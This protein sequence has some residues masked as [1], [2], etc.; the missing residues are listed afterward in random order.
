MLSTMNKTL[1]RSILITLLG[2]P[3][4][5]TAQPLCL[6]FEGFPEG[7]AFGPLL[8][9]S[10][11]DTLFDNQ[12][13]VAIARPFQ[14][15]NGQTGFLNASIEGPGLGWLDSRFLFMGNNALE[16]RYPEAVQEVCFD[17]F[18][19]GGE[20]NLSVNGGEP[21]LLTSFSGMPE[22]AFPGVA[23]ELT[24]Q[25]GNS[26][27][28]QGQ[29][30]LRGNITALLVGGQELGIDNVCASQEASQDS[31]CIGF[32]ALASGA[33]GSSSG[34]Q[35]GTTFYT[36]AGVPM[37]LLPFQSLF[38]ATAYGDVIAGAATGSFTAAAGQAAR[39]Q[40]ANLVLDLT[41]YPE[42]AVEVVADYYYE[43]GAVNFAAN[44]APFLIQGSL[45]AGFFALAPGATLEVVPDSPNAAQGTLRFSGGLQTLLMGGADGLW[46]DNICINPE[47]PACA[48][49]GLAVSFLPCEQ[50]AG[51]F[52]E[53]DVSYESPV[54]DTLAISVG[55]VV[56]YQAYADLPATVGPIP[57]APA[58]LYE[59]FAFDE[60]DPSCFVADTLAAAPCA[61]C[62]MSGMT[63]A[64][65]G[66]NEWGQ[67]LATLDFDFTASASSPYFFSLYFDGELFGYFN[68]N[69][70]PLTFPVPCTSGPV[71]V[72]SVCRGSNSLCC[73]EL[74]IIFAPSC[75]AAC[76]LEWAG[77][78]PVG[79]PECTPGAEGFY[80]ISL[81]FLGV[82]SGDTLLAVSTLTGG[83]AVGI[84][85]DGAATFTLPLIPGNTDEI[86][87]MVYGSPGC[88]TQQIGFDIACELCEVSGF[89]MEPLPCSPGDTAF[90][91]NIDFE[92]SGIHSDTFR[93]HVSNTYQ[94]MVSQ[95]DLPA[96]VGPIPFSFTGINYATISDL[97][98]G[99]GATVAFIPPDCE[100][101]CPLGAPTVV[102]TG[103]GCNEDGTYNV[104]ILVPGVLPGEPLSVASPA[105]GFAQVV[106]Y[107]AG[108]SAILQLSGWP[109]PEGGLDSLVICLDGQPGCCTTVE[110]DVYCE[111][112]CSVDAVLDIVC[113]NQPGTFLVYVA[114]AS[115]GPVFTLATSLGEAS[116]FQAAQLPAFV[117]PFSYPG[118][119]ANISV[120]VSNGSCA[121]F[122][123]EGYSL[124]C[125][126]ACGLGFT[127]LANGAE[128]DDEGFYH[129]TLQL[130]GVSPGDSILIIGQFSNYQA[131][132]EVGPN[133]GVEVNLPDPGTG[134]DAVTICNLE[135]SD[136]CIEA[137]FDIECPPPAEC[138]FQ[139]VEASPSACE[140]GQFWIELSVGV[141]EPG[142]L[143]YLAFV[144]GQVFGPFPY[145]G[146][147]VNL[148]P[149]TAGGA[150][151]YDILVLDFELPTCFGYTEI[152]PIDCE[153]EPCA[154]S[155]LTAVAGP[156]EQDGTYSLFVDFELASPGNEFVEYFINGAFAGFSPASEFPGAIE[157]LMPQG[158]GLFTFEIC[159][160]DQA[161]CCASATFEAPD[162]DNTLCNISD[163]LVG[164][165]ECDEEGFY[166]EAS[167][168]ST[169]VEPGEEY[170]A[171][172][173]GVAYGVFTY[174]GAFPILGPFDPF[175]DQL[176]ELTIADLGHPNCTASTEFVAFDCTGLGEEGC[177]MFEPYTGFATELAGAGVLGAMEGLQVGYEIAENAVQ[178][179]VSVREVGN[180]PGFLTGTGAALYFR[181]AQFSVELGSLPA[182]TSAR[183]LSMDYWLGAG[184]D[185][186][187]VTA[188]DW[189][190]RI[191]VPFVSN[192]YTLE[193]GIVLDFMVL[194]SNF[195]RLSVTGPLEYFAV[196]T[197]PWQAMAIDHLCVGA[198]LEED[199]CLTFEPFA[200]FQSPSS[201]GGD[202]WAVVGTASGVELAYLLGDF[203]NCAFWVQP[204]AGVSYFDAAA[205]EML[206]MEQA[207]ARFVFQQPAA[208]VSFDYSIQE[209][210]LSYLRI[211]EFIHVGLDTLGFNIPI[212][213]PD[214][215]VLEKRWPADSPNGGNS[216]QVIITGA[217]SEFYLDGSG[218]VDN[219][220]WEPVEE[221]VWPGDANADNLAHHVDLL[222]IGLAYG[223]QGPERTALGNSWEPASS[224]NWGP[225]FADGTNFKHADC[226]GDG[227]IDEQDI[228]AIELNY[229]LSHGPQNDLPEL[230]GTA[231]DPPAYV[232][233]PDNQPDGA[234]FQAPIIVGEA[235]QPVSNAY[236]IAFTVTFDPEVIDPSSIEIVYPVS[237]FGEPGINTVNIHKIY[238]EEGRIEMALSRIDHNNVSGHGQVA[239]IIG[240]IDDI[241]GIQES[242]IALEHILCLDKD[243]DLLPIQGLET[244]FTV[245]RD[246]GNEPPEGEGL[247][248]VFPN[249]TT[250]RVAVVSPQGLPLTGLKLYSIQG[251][252][253]SLPASTAPGVIDLGHLPAG[254]YL[255]GVSTG[256]AT[257]YRRIIRQAP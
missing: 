159:V 107:G 206:G 209:S 122:V 43:G 54:S 156:C 117:G 176:Y 95:S 44:G 69:E 137:S 84:V 47:P 235:A 221:E 2:A 102:G 183:T 56:F 197:Y 118:P 48:L 116:Q 86:Y 203:C 174:G 240:V 239:Y 180:I 169:G 196:Q 103:A 66:L 249:P 22:G 154:I 226:N 29:L 16:L 57:V 224:M 39:F 99:C 12:G 127:G 163:L 26:A 198:F 55:D 30:C 32:N 205:G 126:E 186:L 68:N 92:A 42:P 247:F 251:R 161:E 25:T 73:T 67:Q 238:P 38:W 63:L 36:E 220:C 230:P 10:P 5:I 87:V 228:A 211:D 61:S 81:S 131:L 110:V 256:E 158:G 115:P 157:G 31:G 184:T 134:F 199:G 3:F 97:N 21:L 65:A 139:F 17:F 254:V 190:E 50:N 49:S 214:G 175:T 58:N 6:D 119:N 34:V 37:L 218:F 89:A 45:Q 177:F 98:G 136:C 150:A 129:A 236:G 72:L 231:L 124:N 53:V 210:D 125:I 9:Q 146:Q 143:G 90:Y 187:W 1:L 40:E 41:G 93:F 244:H 128:C 192:T 28:P 200:G 204:S 232:D 207:L 123:S 241:A 74:P 78:G 153:T 51:F 15:L 164:F 257:I 171:V 82:E 83:A 35:P 243:E 13:L 149:F 165:V 213:L 208:Q 62:T 52:V 59:V 252:E 148:G 145:N 223:A 108:G 111:P 160:N 170:Q 250:G 105:T 168:N 217:L 166:V 104:P 185:S 242:G 144:D 46:L 20:I 33:Y 189:S 167:F 79:L 216:A 80:D 23:V 142:S 233:F 121:P 4:A 194:A 91:A 246:T 219:L 135:L 85:D 152:G 229:G 112:N 11:G 140:N 172:V 88:F 114:E 225:S 237:W 141:Q 155:G 253:L 212:A 76:S 181:N 60:A 234:I 8:G 106:Q 222:S 19:G 202:D 151:V 179:I 109:A 27:L 178:P 248:R 147:A 195:G 18:D 113:G 100:D 215:N 96:T 71:P 227:I 162:C 182:N 101:G 173:N 132:A 191:Y 7:P 255:L 64:P 24:F 130:T 188:N 94:T 133:L 14:Y 70:L 138:Q 193:N 77:N 245:V 120:E 201:T 75:E